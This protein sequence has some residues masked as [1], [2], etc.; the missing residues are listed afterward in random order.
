VRRYFGAKNIQP[1]LPTIRNGK[2][3]GPDGKKKKKSAALMFSTPAKVAA[4]FVQRRGRPQQQQQR[5]R[6]QYHEGAQLRSWLPAA[7]RTAA[8]III[9]IILRSRTAHHLRGRERI[10]D[11]WYVVASVT[12]LRVMYE[13]TA[14]SHQFQT[15]HDLFFSG[16]PKFVELTNCG[17]TAVDLGT[18]ILTANDPITF[19]DYGYLLESILPAGASYVVSYENGDSPGS[20]T[21]FTMYSE[22]ADFRT[23][24][25]SLPARAP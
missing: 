14:F 22:D 10:A 24:D 11:R 21:F 19:S 25:K 6:R 2:N 7:S 4:D 8:T 5:K 3:T 20:S 15:S 12:L 16:Q 9:I 18:I 17:T 1:A 23:P 13:S